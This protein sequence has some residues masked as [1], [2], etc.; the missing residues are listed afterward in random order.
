MTYRQDSDVYTPYGKM[1]PMPNSALPTDRDLF[2]E[3][4]GEMN[5]D[6]DFLKSKKKTVAW[7]VSNC[8][9]PSNRMDYVKGFCN[10]LFY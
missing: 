6:A 8:D 3:Q 2:I 7:F 1:M 10:Y 5:F 4:F 9:A